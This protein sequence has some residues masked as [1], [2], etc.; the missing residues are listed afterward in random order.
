MH[1][2]VVKAKAKASKAAKSDPV[3]R[4]SS[5]SAESS[6]A[7]PK[8]VKAKAKASKAAKSDSASSRSKSESNCSSSKAQSRHS[9]S[10]TKSTYSRSS[11]TTK[12]SGN[13]PK[14]AV[15]LDNSNA[16]DDKAKDL[17][18]QRLEDLKEGLLKKKQAREQLQQEVLESQC[19]KEEVPGSSGKKEEVPGSS[20]IREDTAEPAA[21]NDAEPAAITAEPKDK[22]LKVESATPDANFG[23]KPKAAEEAPEE[24]AKAKDKEKAPKAAAPD[25][26]NAK[27]N[28]GEAQTAAVVLD[29]TLKELEEEA[30]AQEEKPWIRQKR[31]RMEAAMERVQKGKEEEQEE[32]QNLPA[33]PDAEPVEPVEPME[34]DEEPA[35]PC[36][37]FTA[38]PSL[39]DTP[40]VTVLQEEEVVPWQQSLK[41]RPNR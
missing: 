17:Q 30:Q 16:A 26:E 35:T 2:K 28:K 36:V 18:T 37:E 20:S 22:N 27:E 15:A 11:S 6:L 21:I 38:T 1:P 40:T 19:K 31:R 39:A 29:T 5:P 3:A 23:E 13:A 10:K 9:S 33:E 41:A 12:K 25:E 24:N 7:H 8:V 4:E 34:Q 14:K 32:E